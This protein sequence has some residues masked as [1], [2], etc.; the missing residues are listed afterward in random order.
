MTDTYTLTECRELVRRP[1]KFKG[2]HPMVPFLLD[3]PE[4]A[5]EDGGDT[6]SYLWFVRFGRWLLTENDQGFVHGTKFDTEDEARA[7][8]ERMEDEYVTL[9]EYD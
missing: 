8:F 4:C 5:D 6:E 2:E 7:E 1:G 9:G 3:R